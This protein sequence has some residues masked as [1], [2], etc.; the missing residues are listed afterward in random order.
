[1]FILSLFSFFIM[2]ATILFMPLALSVSNSTHQISLIITGSIFWLTLFVGVYSTII[3]GR[4]RRA[5]CKRFH[6]RIKRDRSFLKL[7]FGLNIVA[8]IAFIIG[9][10]G[11]FVF[12][13]LLI[14]RVYYSYLL[15]VL[16]F[17]QVF[18]L[19]VYCLFN[20]KNFIYINKSR[21]GKQKHEQ[22]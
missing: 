8:R 16:L 2:S 3:L 22:I 12:I 21:E 15:I 20:G 6:I 17:I 10:V 13:I 18:S 1:M 11:L 9:M 7:L 4:R 14:N 5:N 19:C